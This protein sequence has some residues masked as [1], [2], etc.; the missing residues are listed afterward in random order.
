[1]NREDDN[2]LIY[3]SLLNSFAT[4]FDGVSD[5]LAVVFFITIVTPVWADVEGSMAGPSHIE[6]S[7]CVSLPVRNILSTPF[8]RRFSVIYYPSLYRHWSSLP[9]FPKK[10][11]K[12]GLTV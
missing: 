12:F 3:L 10:S 1:M 5:L 7:P 11:S 6:R 8:F 9:L 4:L 2:Y